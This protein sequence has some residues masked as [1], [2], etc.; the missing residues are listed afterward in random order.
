MQSKSGS[1]LLSS[2]SVPQ[3]HWVTKQGTLCVSSS[4]L[5]NPALH[6][7]SAVTIYVHSDLT[8]SFQWAA[9][10]WACIHD[11][12]LLSIHARILPSILLSSSNQSD[13]SKV[14]C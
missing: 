13:L 3:V 8:I 4:R 2:S 7:A 5:Y 11:C 1:R 14:Q 10:G 12:I 6:S 9:R